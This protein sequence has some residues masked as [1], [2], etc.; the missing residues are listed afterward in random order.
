MSNDLNYYIRSFG[1][2]FNKNS[3]QIMEGLLLKN[4]YNK[5]EYPKLA[6][7]IIINT[8]M[9]KINT[10]NKILYLISDFVK[11]YPDKIL[12]IAGCMPEVISK[13]L[14]SIAPNAILIGPFYTTELISLIEK[15]KENLTPK[16]LIGKRIEDKID[17]PKNEQNKLIK[18][19]PISQGCVNSCHYCVVKLAMGK[20]RSY[21]LDKIISYI[22]KSVKNGVKEIQ[23]TAQDLSAY[24]I[25]SK[26]SLIDILAKITKINGEFKTR[27][28][29]MNP[30]T[31]F[32]II[33]G[34][35][36]KCDNDKIYKFF[37]IPVQSGDNV[38]LE[39]MN[40]KYRI[41]DFIE[42]CNKIKKK[43]KD[44]T[45]STDIICGY[46]GETDENFHNTI[47]L[48]KMIKPDII[49]ISKYSHRPGTVASKL[50]DLPSKIKKER[51]TLLYQ[52]YHDYVYEKFENMI[53]KKYRVLFLKKISNNL[54]WGRNE[55]YTPVYV[56]SSNN[57]IGKI[58]EVK[59][60]EL[61]KRR[62]YGILN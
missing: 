20:L 23:L 16:C 8:C 41:E 18:I 27:L 12:I 7:I 59:I 62:L 53:E 33:D 9:V 49:N 56:R 57:L 54:F 4:N 30:S 25:D 58:E 50:K 11:K 5:V 10:E 34:L 38:V 40:R 61:K 32:P 24:G 3:A 2:T 29:M 36:D 51:S 21:P 52:I 19:V 60:I 39:K 1:C 37:H 47:K 22:Q 35:L 28:G 17:S 14:K 45:L 43:F 46:P 31:L 55:K 44:Y 6:N 13:K 42:I 48:I 26:N 15:N